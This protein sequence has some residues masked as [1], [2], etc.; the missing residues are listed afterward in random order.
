MKGRCGT[1]VKTERKLWRWH[2]F[3]QDG[4]NVLERMKRRS[5]QENLL[6]FTV[7]VERW[8]NWSHRYSISA[9]WKMWPANKSISSDGRHGL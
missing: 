4:V 1:D 3:E 7:W 2:V 8:C 9:M 6:T 5:F